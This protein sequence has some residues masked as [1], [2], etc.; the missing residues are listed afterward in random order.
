MTQLGST[1]PSAGPGGSRHG[2]TN[3][4]LINIPTIKKSANVVNSQK[5]NQ[6]TR[7]IHLGQAC[8]VCNM[9]AP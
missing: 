8:V 3:D 5:R 7:G 6:D 1:A 2:R 4:V 9:I